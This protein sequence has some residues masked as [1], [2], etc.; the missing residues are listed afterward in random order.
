MLPLSQLEYLLN[1]NMT[2]LK[3]LNCG[4]FLCWFETPV[5]LRDLGWGPREVGES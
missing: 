3:N 1:E 4:S 5:W 2:L